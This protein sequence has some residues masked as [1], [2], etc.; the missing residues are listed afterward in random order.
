MNKTELIEAIASDAGVT[1]KDVEAMLNAFTDIVGN[2]MKK[3]EKVQI[4]GFGTFEVT[5]RKARQGRN[6]KTGEI[7]KIPAAVAPKFKPGK[8]LK[9]K[10]AKAKIK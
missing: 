3:G 10:A 7:I 9:E 6:P 4:V 8:D 2:T 1:K 5:K